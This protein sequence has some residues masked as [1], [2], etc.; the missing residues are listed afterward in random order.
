M[1]V[2]DP[3]FGAVRKPPSENTRDRSIGAILIDAGRL[4]PEAAEKIL[5]HQKAHNLRFGEAA[6]GLG[7]ITADD[8]KFALAHQ[9]EY[10]Y[11]SPGEKPAT[12]E[13]V[14]AY[15]PNNPCVE[16]MRALR[17]QLMLRWLDNRVDRKS[18]ALVSSERGVGRSFVAANLAVVFSQLGETTLLI[19]ANLRAP[20][21]HRLFKLENKL[22]LSSLLGAGSGHEPIVQ[23]PSFVGLSVLP[24]GPTPP[25]PQELLSR[26]TFRSLIDKAAEQYDVVLIDTPAWTEGADAQIIASRAGAALLVTR[27]DYTA[28]NSATSFVENL[29]QS[30][31]RVLGAVMNKF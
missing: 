14:A 13:V 26:A 5:Q 25:N 15:Q 22:G 1:Q 18:L 12:P 8:V 17:S 10:T 21:M 31:C 4:S 3:V 9:F 30:G 7:L 23:L 20:R 24:A 29:G 28:I 6:I 11:L 16:A 27:L 2:T 19:D